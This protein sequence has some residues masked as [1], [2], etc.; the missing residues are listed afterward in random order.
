[1]CV[2]EKGRDR[3]RKNTKEKESPLLLELRLSIAPALI[4]TTHTRPPQC[5]KTRGWFN[6]AFFFVPNLQGGRK[7]AEKPSRWTTNQR[8]IPLGKTQSKKELQV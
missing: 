8:G 5:T 3:E 6:I 1:V 4:S 2:G 7:G